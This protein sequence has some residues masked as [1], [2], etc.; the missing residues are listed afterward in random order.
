[1]MSDIANTI[2]FEDVR[3]Y[4]G[5]R[6]LCAMFAPEN[7]R[8]ALMALLSFNLELARIPELVSEPLLGQMRI[9]WW[10]QVVEDI[11]S[12]QP[13]SHPVAR[14]LEEPSVRDKLDRRLLLDILDARER[15][16]TDELPE[17]LNALENYASSTGGA[18]NALMAQALGADDNF[19]SNVASPVGV[20]WALTGL[21]RAMAFHRQQGRTYIL[22]EPEQV[23]VTAHAHIAKARA[24]VSWPS[25]KLMPVLLPALLA[26]RHLKKLQKTAYHSSPQDVQGPSSGTL[27]RLYVASVLR[28]F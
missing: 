14:I 10:R 11:Y 20:A 27:F 1:M 6:C 3:R 8:A 17:D 25:R 2:L 7:E 24:A 16:L 26:E 13:S 19:V 12:S 4:D 5:E 21:L 28:R 22:V 15:D 23:A 18:L 9:Q